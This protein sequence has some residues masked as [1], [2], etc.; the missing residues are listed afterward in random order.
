M[1]IAQP[2]KKMLHIRTKGLFRVAVMKSGILVITALSIV[3][4]F[5]ATI[6][7]T[8]SNDSVN[9]KE[10]LARSFVSYATGLATK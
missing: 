1:A 8:S 2:A 5:N 4:A 3:V 7:R 9:Q 10:H 6:A